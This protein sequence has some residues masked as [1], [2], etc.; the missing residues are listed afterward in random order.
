MFAG[1]F[2]IKNLACSQ[3]G[4]ARCASAL[5][6]R[7]AVIAGGRKNRLIRY[8]GAQYPYATLSGSFLMCS[9]SSSR[10]A[11]PVK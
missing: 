11:Q 2:C 4:D 10:V 7:L 3:A 1:R 8:L 9:S 6:K 5:R